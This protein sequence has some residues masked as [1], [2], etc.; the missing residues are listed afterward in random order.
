V[1]S[2][3]RFG[4]IVGNF[5]QLAREVT[6]LTFKFP[7]RGIARADVKTVAGVTLDAGRRRQ[8]NLSPHKSFENAFMS[9]QVPRVLA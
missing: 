7:D 3:L 8:M 4:R 5:A 1:K 9:Q 2:L 6:L